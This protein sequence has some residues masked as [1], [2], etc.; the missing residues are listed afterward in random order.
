MTQSMGGDLNRVLIMAGGTGGH[1]YPALSI[2][3]ALRSRG[4]Q[5]YWLGTERGLE[6]RVAAQAGLPIFC[7]QMVGVRGK[8]L[9][10]LCWAPFRLLRAVWQA[11]KI[12][13]GV[14]PDVVLGMGG[15][16][17]APGGLAAWLLR[18]PLVLHEQNA[19]PGMANRLLAPLA[20]RV[21]EAFE[22]SFPAAR[23]AVYT[24]NP[25]RAEIT[26]IEPP[27]QRLRGRE[28]PLRLLVL[29]GSQGAQIFNELI[30]Q[31]LKD[32]VD[33]GR[34]EVRHQAGEGHLQAA[35]A[36]YQEAG[37][38][39]RPVGFFADMAEVYAWADLVVCRAGAITI[40]E[41]AAVGAASVLV[42]FPFATDDHQT[43]NARHLADR[44]GAILIQQS[45]LS[46]VRLSELVAGFCNAPESL[47]RMAV[48]ARSLA[49]PDATD[50]V[51]ASCLEAAHG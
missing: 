8:G 28:G 24:G 2:A 14:H 45:A 35:C 38:A 20:T 37:L 6:S 10:A 15:Y 44:G 18:K 29:G 11:I 46:A 43:R 4:T 17:S 30:P 49:M 40:A 31:A 22:G 47:R 16:V 21:L 39:V 23:R 3:E 50:R 1:V 51:V 9:R 25:V 27:E 7:V 33:T 12:V 5:V 41:L 48:A 36:A 32:L 34:V 42:P 13:R 26:R 19:V